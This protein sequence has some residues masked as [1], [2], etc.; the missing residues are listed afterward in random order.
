MIPQ[1]GILVQKIN[2]DRIDFGMLA[3]VWPGEDEH[4]IVRCPKCNYRFLNVP[5]WEN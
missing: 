2:P 3:V 1:G 4:F 5:A